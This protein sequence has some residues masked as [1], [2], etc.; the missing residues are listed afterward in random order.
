[1]FYLDSHWEVYLFITVSFWCTYMYI[2]RRIKIHQNRTINQS[3]CSCDKIQWALHIT[4]R[5]PESCPKWL[6]SNLTYKRPNPVWL[7]TVLWKKQR[8]PL[9]QPHGACIKQKRHSQVQRHMWQEP[10][11]R[12]H[13]PCTDGCAPW[14]IFRADENGK[15][16]NLRQVLA[17][18]KSWPTF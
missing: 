2:Y 7:K 18:R 10:M 9:P 4:F 13:A 1:M 16:L 15:H 3:I 6:G 17:F 11:S 5:H 12:Q 8:F 14:Y